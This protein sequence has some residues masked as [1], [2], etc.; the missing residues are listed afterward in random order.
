M[1]ITIQQLANEIIS[2][3]LARE[4]ELIGCSEAEIVELEATFNLSLPETYRQWLKTMGRG[5]GHF[6]AGSDAFYPTVIENRKY[7]EE[8]LAETGQPFVLEPDA[9]VFLIHQGYQ[10]LYFLTHEGHP[11]PPVIYHL[12]GAEPEQRWTHLTDYYEQVLN[13]TRRAL[14]QLADR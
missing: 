2:S 10:F 8:L 14:E 6:L 9:F 11:D 13:D 7:A 1:G 5:A 12:E 3:G 4:S